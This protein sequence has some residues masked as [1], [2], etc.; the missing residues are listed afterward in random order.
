MMQ[1][2][3]LL[4]VE[5]INNDDCKRERMKQSKKLLRVEWINNDDCERERE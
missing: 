4:R 2:K 3:K 5:Q 1:S